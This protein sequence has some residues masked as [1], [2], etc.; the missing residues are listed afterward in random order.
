LRQKSANRINPFLPHPLQ[1]INPAKFPVN[2]NIDCHRKANA[3]SHNYRKI[4]EG[5]F[6]ARFLKHIR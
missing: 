3:Y 1:V 5:E 6:N 4:P 2:A